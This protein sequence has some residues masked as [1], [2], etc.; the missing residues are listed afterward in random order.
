L[1]LKDEKEVDPDDNKVYDKDEP[2]K[3]EDKKEELKKKERENT[4]LQW[5]NDNLYRILKDK[6]NELSERIQKYNDE[7][8]ILKRQ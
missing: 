5:K 1:K 2:K 8:N 6:A 3:E 7:L 4:A